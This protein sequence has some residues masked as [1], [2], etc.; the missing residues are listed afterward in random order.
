MNIL[1]VKAV[2]QNPYYEEIT[3]PIGLMVIASM[4]REH[5]NHDVRILDLRLFRKPYQ[6]FE[7]ILNTFKPDIIGI[8]AIS[9]EVESMTRLSH[10]AKNFN[11]GITIISGG[12]HTTL[13]PDETLANE[14]ID[15]GVIGEGEE[16]IIE[17]L[18]Y[19]SNPDKN[20]NEIRGIVYRKEGKIIK[21]DNRPWIENLDKLPLPAWDLVE[22]EKY[23][24]FKGGSVFGGRKF[25]T[26]I[27][28]RGCPLNCI[29]CTHILGKRF[30]G[31]SP[32]RVFSEIKYIKHNF[33]ID[34]FEILDDIFNFDRKRVEKIC[35]LIIRNNLNIKL[36]IA[37]LRVDLL[38]P[39]L[40]NMFKKA[41][42]VFI[43][44]S[45]ESASKRIQKLVKRNLNLEK[46]NKAISCAYKLNI[47]TLGFFILGFPTET[48]EEIMETIDF[49]ARSALTTASFFLLVPFKGTEL[50]K[51]Y[52]K[53][54]TRVEKTDFREFNFYTGKYNM[55]AVSDAKLLK[56]RNL[57]YRKFYLKPK[58][59][60]TIIRLYHNKRFLLKLG[61]GTFRR[62]FSK[63]LFLR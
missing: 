35:D 33:E 52:L 34:E 4:I 3:H 22:L 43:G 48:E 31:M 37:Q 56:L 59:I 18:S 42:V 36:Y 6:E 2:Q 32:E 58:R 53:N 30:R 44:F 14:D 29:Y 28:S 40:L 27:T 39:A 8:S 54:S 5:T 63:F 60:F 15:Y 16:T 51:D 19:L 24:N 55:S 1:L 46:T 26:L 23:K 17:L 7:S 62:M 10:I 45:I 9:L 13:Y 11:K 57:A 47:F 41:G 25:A 49:A 12:P 38:D 50:W 20:I 61:I 21:T